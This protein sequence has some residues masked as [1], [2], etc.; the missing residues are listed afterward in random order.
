MFTS[1]LLGKDNKQFSFVKLY[2]EHKFCTF[3]ENISVYEQYEIFCH[4][5]TQMTNISS[6]E[7]LNTLLKP[8]SQVTCLVCTAEMVA[9]GF[10]LS[11]E[12]GSQVIRGSSYCS[13]QM[14]DVFAIVVGRRN[15]QKKI[16]ISGNKVKA[17]VSKSLPHALAL[18][19]LR[20][21]Q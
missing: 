2:F 14:G 12:K 1:S 15:Y 11:E 9:F 16:H 19:G 3:K 5:N 4:I 10:I 21:L 18:W 8:D 13:F 20:C 7:K 17:S 6:I